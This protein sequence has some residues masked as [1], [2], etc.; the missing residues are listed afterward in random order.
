MDLTDAVAAANIG[1]ATKI[2][3]NREGKKL[4]LDI[5]VGERTEKK[6][7]KL[8]EPPMSS[9]KFQTQDAPYELGFNVTNIS[10]SLRKEY[11]IPEDL[12][13]PVVVEV[14]RNS[15]AGQ[16]GLEPGDVILDVNRKEVKTAS[17][18]LNNLKKGT[19]TL[20]VSRD[21]A[22]AILVL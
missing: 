21:N 15:T 10:D 20:R 11:D 19:N 18:V 14:A 1:A 5:I 8:E 12:D 4:T 6:I 9:K 22:I 17:D 16:A 13:G 3:V 7:A 2:K